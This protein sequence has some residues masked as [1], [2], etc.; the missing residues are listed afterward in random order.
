MFIINRNDEIKIILQKYFPL[1][2][3][4]L[5]LKKEKEIL[6]NESYYY[7]KQIS[8]LYNK[9]K[10]INLMKHIQIIN[11][12]LEKVNNELKERLWGKYLSSLRF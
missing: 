10:Y 12:S 4:Q 9:N 7:Y 3:I 11:G 1:E 5:I 6:L 2:I 8:R